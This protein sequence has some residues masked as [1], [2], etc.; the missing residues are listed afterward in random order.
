[1]RPA[2]SRPAPNIT[3]SSVVEDEVSPEDVA[4]DQNKPDLQAVKDFVNSLDDVQF[5][6]LQEITQKRLEAGMDSSD[7]ADRKPAEMVFDDMLEEN[8]EM[9]RSK[10]V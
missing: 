4:E 10:T 1:M 3:D 9:P 2:N 8:E 5:G 6:Y 7:V